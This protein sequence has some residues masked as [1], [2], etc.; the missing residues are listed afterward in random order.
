[1]LGQGLATL[2]RKPADLEHER[3]LCMMNIEMGWLIWKERG[4]MERD[5]QEERTKMAPL[6]KG[7]RERGRWE[8]T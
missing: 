3:V 1:M 4:A 2:F 7:A 5:A 8:A 6:K